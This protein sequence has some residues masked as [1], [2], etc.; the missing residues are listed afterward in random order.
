MIGT[1]G[2]RVAQCRGSAEAFRGIPC[3]VKGGIGGVGALSL[4]GCSFERQERQL[5]M[6]ATK[7]QS[8]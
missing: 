1:L 7:T 2:Y 8:A 3:E 5:E 6:K 4:P